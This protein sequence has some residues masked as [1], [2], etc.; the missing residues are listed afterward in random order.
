MVYRGAATTVSKLNTIIKTKIKK[1][2]TKTV[3]KI[4][5]AKALKSKIKGNAEPYKFRA[6]LL[7]TF[8]FLKNALK[9]ISNMYEFRIFRYIFSNKAKSPAPPAGLKKTL[10]PERIM[11]SEPKARKAEEDLKTSVPEPEIFFVPAQFGLENIEKLDVLIWHQTEE[12]ICYFWS[13]HQDK[14]PA[15][16]ENDLANYKVATK[17]GIHLVIK[18]K[19]AYCWKYRVRQI[20]GQKEVF[21]LEFNMT[22]LFKK[23]IVASAIVNFSLILIFL[24]VLWKIIYIQGNRFEEAI[25]G[26]EDGLKEIFLSNYKHVLIE[27]REFVFTQRIAN[28][29]NQMI[30]FFN[31]HTEAKQREYQQDSLMGI[32]TRRYLMSTLEKEIIRAQRYERALAFILI[33]MDDFKKINDTYGHLMGDKVLRQTAEILKDQTRETDIVARYGGEEI[34]VIL[35]ETEIA[36]ALGVAEKLR[37]AVEKTKFNFQKQIVRVTI[38]LGVANLDNPEDTMN[39]LIRR[40]DKALYAAKQKGRNRVCKQAKRIF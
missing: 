25:S 17:S 40:A 14:L 9:A 37:R 1:I 11:P 33:D 26:I 6:I 38:S 39:T 3:R 21:Y 22:S 20:F 27:A 16:V 2:E 12:K 7:K 31:T 5:E 13:R 28:I 18:S 24:L 32:Y 36:D 19:G 4:S 8:W 34:A 23:F 15:G 29:M 35:S 10:Q 30:Y